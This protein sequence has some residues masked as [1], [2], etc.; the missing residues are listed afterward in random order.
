MFQR[1][2]LAAAESNGVIYASG[3]FDGSKYLQ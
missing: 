2:A 1:F 3:G